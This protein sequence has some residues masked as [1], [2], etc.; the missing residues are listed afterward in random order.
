[1]SIEVSGLT[2]ERA[3]RP[4]LRDL[5]F[6]AAR[7]QVLAL[8]GASG[9]GKSTLLRCLNRLAE[10]RAGTIVLDG[11]DIRALDPPALR[12]RVALVAQ[13]PAMLPGTVQDNL[14]YGLTDPRRRRT[15]RRA[16]RRRPGPVASRPAARASCRAAS[17][18]GWRSRAR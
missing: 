8:V 16:D 2:V 4:V 12:R 18:P 6:D 13:T 10:P 11:T 1:M 9:S 15:R 14:A 17:A 7:G 3:G 5:T